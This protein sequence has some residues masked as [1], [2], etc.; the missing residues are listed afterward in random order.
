MHAYARTHAC[1]HARTHTRMH[2]RMHAYTHTHAHIHTQGCSQ[3]NPLP[4]HKA[5]RLL[6]LMTSSAVCVGGEWVESERGR[7]SRGE[8]QGG[9]GREG[10]RGGGGEG[11]QDNVMGMII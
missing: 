10:M 7:T 6:Y 3:L 8:S 11:G 5:F 1:M 4:L 9:G 2:A